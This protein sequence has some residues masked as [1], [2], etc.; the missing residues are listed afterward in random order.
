[1]QLEQAVQSIKAL[2]ARRAAYQHALGVMYY[3]SVTVAPPGG[4]AA[5]GA[6]LVNLSEQGF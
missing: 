6:A 3:D 5:R 1:M 2:Q 4:V